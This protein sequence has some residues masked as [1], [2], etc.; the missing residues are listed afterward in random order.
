MDTTDGRSIFDIIGVPMKMT[1]VPEKGPDEQRGEEGE[2]DTATAKKRKKFD[3]STE[4][5]E[6]EK[7][8][9]NDSEDGDPDEE[10][11]QKKAKRETAL[12][13]N[14][15]NRYHHN[16]HSPYVIYIT[17]NDPTDNLGN[18]HPMKVD[19]KVRNHLKGIIRVKRQSKDTVAMTFETPQ[20]ANYAVEKFEELS[21]RKWIAYIPGHKIHREGMVKGVWQELS[22]NE[23]KENM[24]IRPKVEIIEVLRI[25]KKDNKGNLVPTDRIRITFGG[26][27]LPDEVAI[28]HKLCKVEP[29][30]GTVMRCYKCQHFGHSTRM[31]RGNIRCDFCAGHHDSRIC[32]NRG[33][34][35]CVNCGESHQA[36][37][38]LCESFIRETAI[39]RI[40]AFNN[41]S[42]SEAKRDLKETKQR[43]TNLFRDIGRHIKVHPSVKYAEVAESY[44]HKPYSKNKEGSSR[45]N[46]RKPNPI[47]PLRRTSQEQLEIKPTE[48]PKEEWRVIKSNSDDSSDIEERSMI[49]EPISALGS[50]KMKGSEKPETYQENPVNKNMIIHPTAESRETKIPKITNNEKMTTP[51]RIIS[52]LNGPKGKF[53]TENNNKAEATGVEE[54]SF[55]ITPTRYSQRVKNGKSEYKKETSMI[56]QAQPRRSRNG[57]R[58][59]II[60]NTKNDDPIK[61]ENNASKTENTTSQKNII[62]EGTKSHHN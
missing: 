36:S 13:W 31:C 2:D 28:F 44:P 10:R 15:H 49:K 38:R 39:K 58:E 32:Q 30:I 8:N 33:K 54:D 46:D 14:Q 57:N 37:S 26:T 7:E 12:S 62:A 43:S 5:F 4:K 53:W 45:T 40:M 19:K 42:Y 21:E 34:L 24:E 35:E 18:Y 61:N 23:I 25:K 55:L 50:I 1:K 41:I 56:P 60:H 27:N 16:S 6:E 29:F 22:E 11:A 17:S 48:T 52:T 51:V 47:Q 20:D 59:P 9:K 3:S